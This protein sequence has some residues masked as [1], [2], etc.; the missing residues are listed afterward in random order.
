MK[1]LYLLITLIVVLSSGCSKSGE[2]PQRML[3]ASETVTDYYPGD[4]TLTYKVSMQYD[5]QNRLTNVT[6]NYGPQYLIAYYTYSYDANS[7][8]I[9]LAQV[10]GTNPI[11]VI[12]YKYLNGVPISAFYQAATDPAPTEAAEYETF[13]NNKITAVDYPNGGNPITETLTYN[14][15]NYNQV[16]YSD[17]TEYQYT[18][19]THKSPFLY[20]G[21]KYILYKISYVINDNEILVQK[22]T[23]PSGAV[24]NYTHV[25]QYNSQGYPTRDQE[26]INGTLNTT[27]DFNYTPYK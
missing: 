20:T 2:S 21:F 6:K 18:Y 3:I 16:I 8:V 4:S 11:G 5:N 17:G 12:T 23:E 13:N 9:S 27:V 22:V 10:D 7:N 24:Y 15:D 19:G 26:S 1:N 25:Y 14:K